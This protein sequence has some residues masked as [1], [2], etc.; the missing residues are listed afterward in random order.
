M[1]TCTSVLPGALISQRVSF[2]SIIMSWDRL[3]RSARVNVVVEEQTPE[4]PQTR[5]YRW[6]ERRSQTPNTLF[7][8]GDCAP[9]ILGSVRVHPTICRSCC[10]E[11]KQ[12]CARRSGVQAPAGACSR[13]AAGHRHRK[14]RDHRVRPAA[15]LFGGVALH[16]RAGRD[17]RRRRDPGPY[18]RTRAVNAGIACPTG[19]R[20]VAVG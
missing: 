6:T 17:V 3:F 4:G 14:R 8:S 18:R 15:S 11:E 12:V 1:K 2:I 9:A 16:R 13:P 19:G 5:S 7:A 10:A 20:D